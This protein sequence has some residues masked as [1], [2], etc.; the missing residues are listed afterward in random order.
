M[1]PT[2]SGWFG[3]PFLL[4]YVLCMTDTQSPFLLLCLELQSPVTDD[5]FLPW[6]VRSIYGPVQDVRIPYQQKRMFGFVT[7]VY[8]ETVKLILAK[9]NPHFVCDSRVLVKPY[10]EKGKVPDNSSS[11]TLRGVSSLHARLP[12]P[13]TPGMPMTTFNSSVGSLITTPAFSSLLLL[14]LDFVAHCTDT[15][16]LSAAAPE[17]KVNSGHGLL[18]QQA[19]SAHE[20]N[21]NQ[22]G[23]FQERFVV[24]T[25][26]FT[27]FSLITFPPVCAGSPPAMEQLE[28]KGGGEEAGAEGEEDV[29][30]SPST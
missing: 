26:E 25:N 21:P 16:S 13:W 22:D 1:S 7:F 2:T 29:P 17:E 19:E 3:N 10:K 14:L 30:S 23:G 28:C 9:G 12:R 6:W 27:D 15:K 5:S 11:S 20:A 18:H 8:P 24:K 4:T